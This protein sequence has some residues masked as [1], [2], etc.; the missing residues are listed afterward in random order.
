VHFGKTE[1]AK[2]AVPIHPDLTHIVTARTKD[3]AANAFL[4]HELPE[5]P[6]SRDSRSDPAVKRFTRYRRDVGVDE[7]PNDK[8]RSNVDFH[9]FRRWFIRKARD[10]M[11]FANGAFTPWTLADLVGHDDEGAQDLLRLTMRHYPGRS[12]DTEKRA[13]VEA[14]KL[15]PQPAPESGK[16]SS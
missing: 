16:V 1:N 9:S 2:R 3:K 11:A 8:A 15:P 13:C 4:F 12:A 7:R 14:V 10:A 6:P 5:L